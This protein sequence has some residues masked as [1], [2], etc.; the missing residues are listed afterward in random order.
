MDTTG[1]MPIPIPL[2]IIDMVG[3]VLLGIGLIEWLDIYSIVPESMRFENYEVL[4]MVVGGLLAFVPMTVY[5]VR[6][7]TEGKRLYNSK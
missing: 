3:T 7:S 5:L 2:M 6:Q 1:K 4:L